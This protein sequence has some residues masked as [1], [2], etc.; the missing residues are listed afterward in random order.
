M[1]LSVTK[2]ISC[3][4][5]YPRGTIHAK[6]PFRWKPSRFFPEQATRRPP[7]PMIG[8]ERA[9][10]TPGGIWAAGESHP[11]SEAQPRAEFLTADGRNKTSTGKSD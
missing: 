11:V 8:A 1:S 10:P 9:R 6:D 4:Q 7:W 5:L 3:L 2:L